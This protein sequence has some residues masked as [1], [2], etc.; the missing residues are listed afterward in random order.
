MSI[1]P[2][3]ISAGTL[4]PV[5]LAGWWLQQ[6]QKNAGWVDVIWAF[7]VALV[8]L[9]Y[10]VFG[11]GD[12]PLRT[13]TGFLYVLWFGRLGFHL[14]QRVIQDP[15]E[16]GRYAYLREWA[17]DRATLVFLILYLLQ[18]SWVW[19]F[20]LPAWL[21]SQGQWPETH[22]VV[23]ALIVI[24]I[25]WMG[26]MLA[27]KQLSEFKQ[28]PANRGKTCRKGLW[29]YS[30]HP[31]Y[32]FEW[33]HWFAYPLLAMATPYGEW[34]WLSPVLMFGFLYFMTG[35]PFTE[36]QAIRSRG[37]DYREYQRTTSMF[38]PWKPK[39]TGN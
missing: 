7:S 39:Q 9:A 23:L 38:F 28:N 31:N 26:E 29:R 20:T 30:R 17:G 12:E 13:L 2:L 19:L 27:D 32:F 6:K 10:C 21:L 5:F 4:L 14:A 36:Q 8:G 24:S 1:Q 33:C 16:D 3:I 15:Q 34:L 35:I 11:H 18:A 37:D 25:A 22:W